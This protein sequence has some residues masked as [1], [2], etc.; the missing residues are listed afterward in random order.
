MKQLM[1]VL[2]LLMSIAGTAHAGCGNHRVSLYG[3][4]WC[5]EC[6]TAKQFLAS[7]KVSYRWIEV[8]GNRQVQKSML[9]QFGM[10]AVPAVVIDGR[11][12]MGFDKGWV[13]KALCLR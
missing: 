3:A 13:R 5:S 2:A 11:R 6:H 9:R 7:Y 8:T 10:V 4:Y 1:L 12:R